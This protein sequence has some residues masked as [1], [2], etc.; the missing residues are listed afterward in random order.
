MT[1]RLPV[2]APLGAALAFTMLA[3]AHAQ[4]APAIRAFLLAQPG[5]VSPTRSAESLV[6]AAVRAGVANGQDGVSLA[7]RVLRE[8]RAGHQRSEVASVALGAGGGPQAVGPELEYNDHPGLADTAVA[9]ANVATGVITDGDVDTF[10]VQV[11]TDSVVRFVTAGNGANQIGDTILV[12]TD[13]DGQL[14]D[15]NDDTAVDLYS[16]IDARLPAGTYFVK[17]QAGF[18]AARN[19]G[20]RL[21]V[22]INPVV[23]PT[24]SSGQS[25]NAAFS[26]L[27]DRHV[28][29]L[30][31]TADSAVTLGTTGAGGDLLLSLHRP[32]MGRVHLVDDS[33]A[34][35]YPALTTRLPAGRFYVVVTP[36]PFAPPGAYRISATIAPF[37]LP[38]APCNG[39]TGGSTVGAETHHVFRLVNAAPAR[40]S[41]PSSSCSTTA[42]PRSPTTTTR[43]PATACSTP[44]CRRAPITW[45]CG[46]SRATPAPTR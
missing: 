13:V 21:A 41:T 5:V 15:S 30:T 7:K 39:S 46:P 37:A 20:Y 14:I 36:S 24:L 31:L 32:Q 18:G 29:A 19:S 12:L 4:D 16:Q 27:A 8:L 3:P 43:T 10:R 45:W 1:F 35:P 11:A 9:G 40:C 17:V 26:T 44:R 25:I 6:A 23:I 42:S 28:Y 2:A 38:A 33:V 22:T 34:G